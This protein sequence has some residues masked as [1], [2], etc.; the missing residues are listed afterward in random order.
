MTK[1]GDTRMHNI[2]SEAWVL[3]AG[4]PNEGPGKLV[5]EP[6]SFREITEHEALVEPIYGSWEG[7]MTHAIKR[8][9]VDICRL[10]KEAKVVI[11]NSGVV[12]I[13]RV[14]SAVTSVKAGD[15]GIVFAGL[16]DEHGFL[17]LGNTYAYDAPGTIG[18]LTKRSKL[19]ENQIL[20]LP[21]NT[22]H[23][24]PTW[25]VFSLRYLTAYNNWNLA[26]QCFRSQMSEQDCPVPWVWGWGG[27]STLAELELA[28]IAG[29]KTAMMSSI[30]ER[31]RYI[32]GRGILPIDRRQ[33]PN[34]N[35]NEEQYRS[36][37]A[38]KKAYDES[39]RIFLKLV[40][41]HTQG[42]G[43][44]IFV[45]YI[46]APVSVATQR[47][48]SRQGVLTTAGWKGGMKITSIRALECINRHIHVH[49]HYARYSDGLPAIA[50][51]ESTDWLPKIGDRVWSWDEIPALAE[52]Y[53][54]GRTTD[55]FPVYE[56]NSLRGSPDHVR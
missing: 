15:L 51:A 14:G 53:A 18:M 31:L 2:T 11:G 47:A 12:R 9:P 25:A 19:R 8:D 45:D 13:L 16:W 46:G 20:P 7:N 55:Y 3:H 22:R 27:G 39:E 4:G 54:A 10:R 28:R 42:Q 34:L 6:F 21:K 52:D 36:D 56:V 43:V 30:P 44:S 49:T 24:L 5:K 38:F 48:L 37:P 1:E 50:L 32:E 35:Y 41:E 26:Y 33:F 29:C 23:S 40:E 17:T